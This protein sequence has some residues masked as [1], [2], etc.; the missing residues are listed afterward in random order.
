M[1]PMTT[2]AALPATTLPGCVFAHTTATPNGTAMR[3]KQLG[4]W[5][6]ITWSEYWHSLVAVALEL[7]ARG[8][9]PGD[10]VAILSDNRPEWLFSDLGAQLIGALAVGIYQTNPPE[11]VAYILAHSRSKVLFAEDQ[12]QL[13][14]ALAITA[15]TP[16]LT[17]IVIFDPRGTRHTSDPRLVTWD[18]FIASGRQR[19]NN[20]PTFA[21]ERLATL[22]PHTPSMVVYTSGT[23]GPPKGALLS[24]DN[25]LST[26]REVMPLFALGP[27]DYLLSY[28]PLCHVAEKIF[29]FFL[30]LS[31]GAVVHFGESI[32]TVQT[33][34]RDVSPTVFLGVPRIWEK[35]HAS[36]TLKMKDASWLKRT[37][38]NRMLARRAAIT[39]HP[40]KPSA[41]DKLFWFISD[42]FVFRALRHRLGLARCRLPVSGAAPISSDL[43]SWFHAIGVRVVEGYGQTECGGVS[44]LNLPNAFKLGTV[45][46]RIPS[47]TERLAE[48]GEILVK[49]PAVFRGYLHDPEATARTVDADGWL[50]TG[51]VGQLDKDGY[52]S[53]TGRKKEIIITSGGKNISPEKVENALKLSPYIK[54]A[55]AIG[56]ARAYLSALIQIDYDTVGDWASRKNLAYGDYPDLASKPEVT[57]LIGDAV[58]EANTH[59]AQV[60]HIRAFKL[61]P[62]ELNQDDGELTATQKVRR[63]E[64]L[65]RYDGLIRAMYGDKTSASTSTSPHPT[66]TGPA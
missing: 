9:R 23:T 12:E 64:V 59:L 32:A 37:L 6:E 14:K 28:L 24:A 62:R 5:R 17:T 27:R 21:A 51:D 35:M 60:E 33:D 42:L 20:A 40:S 8:V 47:F 66:P 54:E 52:L 16:M 53:I 18:A 36:T 3:D 1:T 7:E 56:D 57:A 30:P 10:A 26:A 61:L 48:D 19:L 46:R 25:V 44:H 58:S 45:G 31:S 65:L 22:D 63:R 34:L 55:I 39:R 11:D 15:D 29:T 13:D 49:G 41:L 50:H 4:L 2:P 43:L 38:Y